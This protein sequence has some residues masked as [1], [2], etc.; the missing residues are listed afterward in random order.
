M[1]QLVEDHLATSS[2]IKVRPDTNQAPTDVRIAFVTVLGEPKVS[3]L[4]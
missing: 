4:V 1:Q 3:G 2:V